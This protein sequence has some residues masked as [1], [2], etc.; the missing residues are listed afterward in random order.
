[1][2]GGWIRLQTLPHSSCGESPTLSVGLG[3]HQGVVGF[4]PGE[5]PGEGSARGLFFGLIPPPVQLHRVP[6]R[7]VCVLHESE[8]HLG[9]KVLPALQ[10]GEVERLLHAI[11]DFDCPPMPLG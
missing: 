2:R 3:G 8:L 1:M 9:D 4:R 10:I 6:R 7:L 5:G 11:A